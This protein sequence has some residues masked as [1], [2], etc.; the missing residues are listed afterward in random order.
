MDG[1]LKEKTY[2][3]GQCQYK[4]SE[5]ATLRRHVEAIHEGVKYPS[6]YCQ[7]LVPNP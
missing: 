2:H 1:P 7:A 6:K 3:C 5:N 4:A